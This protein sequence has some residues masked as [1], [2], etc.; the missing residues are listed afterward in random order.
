MLGWYIK[1]LGWM[2]FRLVMCNHI[3]CGDMHVWATSPSFRSLH[4][5]V[6]FVYAKPARQNEHSAAW[7]SVPSA[8]VYGA[9]FSVWNLPEMQERHRVVLMLY[10]L[11]AWQYLQDAADSLFRWWYFPWAHVEHELLVSVYSVPAAQNLQIADDSS[12][13]SGYIPA[14]QTSHTLV[15]RVN[16]V[17]AK[18][19]LHP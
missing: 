9:L 10:F 8:T 16:G 18:Q 6:V 4:K 1:T 15:L 7:T 3:C 2:M 19:Y 5:D 12:F 14:E 17:T 13:K 11:P